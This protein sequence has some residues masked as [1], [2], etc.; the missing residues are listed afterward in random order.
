VTRHLDSLSFTSFD[1]TTMIFLCS[2]SFS[3]LFF[4]LSISRFSFLS[5]LNK[6][7]AFL[8]VG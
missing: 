3:F 7:R 5:S 2:L 8:R 6:F 4:H 1:D